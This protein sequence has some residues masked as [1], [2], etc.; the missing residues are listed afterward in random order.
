MIFDL[1]N[2]AGKPALFFEEQSR[3]ADSFLRLATL[4][5][6]KAISHD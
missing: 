3:K 4:I 2:D 6:F 5:Y 1:K